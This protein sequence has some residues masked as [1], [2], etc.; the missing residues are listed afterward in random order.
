[1]LQVQNLRKANNSGK[2]KSHCYSASRNLRE[3]CELFQ[4]MKIM[5]FSEKG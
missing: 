4:G 2:R 1:M 5:Y 3:V